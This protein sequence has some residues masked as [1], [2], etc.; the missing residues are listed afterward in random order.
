M[1][2]VCV[3]VLSCELAFLCV[4]VCASWVFEPRAG[5]VKYDQLVVKH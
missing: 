3:R 4:C 2:S 5:S 1:G